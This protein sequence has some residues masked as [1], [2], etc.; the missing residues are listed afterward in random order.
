MTSL[1]NDGPMSHGRTQVPQVET[2]HISLLNVRKDSRHDNMM[3]KEH[4]NISVDGEGGS[5]LVKCLCNHTAMS[6]QACSRGRP[7]VAGIGI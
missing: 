1:E 3:A 5:D 2:G 7:S 4:R 6:L